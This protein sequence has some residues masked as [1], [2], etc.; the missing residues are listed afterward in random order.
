VNVCVC[1]AKMQKKVSY[2]VGRYLYRELFSRCALCPDLTL[3]RHSNQFKTTPTTHLIKLMLVMD[4]LLSSPWE[5]QAISSPYWEFTFILLLLCRN[6]WQ[7][8]ICK[9]T[10]DNRREW[11]R[12]K[13]RSST[14]KVSRAPTRPIIHDH[15]KPATT[16]AAAAA[17][18]LG[19]VLQMEKEI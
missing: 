7:K 3:H 18:M 4:F 11:K 6:F 17:V 1:V 13:G 2:T 10:Q 12:V 15:T 14:R 5:F 8:Y 9:H 16:A 19:R